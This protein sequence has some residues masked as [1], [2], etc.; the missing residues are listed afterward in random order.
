MD[1]EKLLSLLDGARK[2]LSESYDYLD[3]STYID[4]M[5]S[6]ESDINKTIKIAS[7]NIVM[8]KVFDEWITSQTTVTTKVGLLVSLND[9]F[10]CNTSEDLKLA[11]WLYDEDV[12][13]PFLPKESVSN[14][15]KYI[16]CVD[17]IINGYEVEK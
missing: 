6:I 5:Q 1:K 15:D 8:P 12:N 14:D 11:H 3:N 13:N 4:Y 10:Y 17:A 2:K 16:R 7:S 9:V